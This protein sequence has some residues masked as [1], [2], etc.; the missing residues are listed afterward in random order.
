MEWVPPVIGLAIVVVLIA[1]LVPKP[2]EWANRNVLGSLLLPPSPKGNP[3]GDLDLS[4]LIGGSA[5]K[6]HDRS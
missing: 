4:A 5:K 2:S 1:R 6:E 3:T